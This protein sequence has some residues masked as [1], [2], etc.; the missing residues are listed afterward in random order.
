M[1]VTILPASK[2][3]SSVEDVY[4]AARCAEKRIYTDEEVCRL[5]A[6]AKE[7]LYFKE[8]QIRKQTFKTIVRFLKTKGN[9]RTLMDL[10]C[11]NGWMCNNLAKEGYAVTGVDINKVELEQAARLFSTLPFYYADVMTAT[12]I[13]KFD[14]VLLAAALQYFPEPEKLIRHLKKEYLHSDGLIVIADTKFY[15]VKDVNEA[16]ER[17]LTYYRSIQ[18]PLMANNYFHHAA[19][20]FRSFK[21]ERIRN[22]YAGISSF[23]FFRKHPFDIY[24][25]Y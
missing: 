21:H 4:L 18:Q 25:V 17:S 15:D 24:I 9:I 12:K 3:F 2:N 1:S 7:H 23:P 8:W 20:I 14:A 5:P 19:K 6:I 13:G 11:G 10:G 22:S 16:S